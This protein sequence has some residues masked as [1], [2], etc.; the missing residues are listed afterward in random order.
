MIGMALLWQGLIIQRKCSA[1]ALPDV[2]DE[3]WK[4]ALLCSSSIV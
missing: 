1:K 3:K 2:L 4:A